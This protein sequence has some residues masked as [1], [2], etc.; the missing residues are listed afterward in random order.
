MRVAVGFLIGTVI[1]FWLLG[2]PPTEMLAGL[3]MMRG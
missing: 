1:L 3:A 2:I